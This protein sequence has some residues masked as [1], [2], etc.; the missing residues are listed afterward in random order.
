MRCERGE[1]EMAAARVY[2][3]LTKG[4]LH[5]SIHITAVVPSSA[6]ASLLHPQHRL[7]MSVAWVREP[8]CFREQHSGGSMPR[9]VHFLNV[10]LA[11]LDCKSLSA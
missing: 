4:S 5:W 6:W 1:M 8:A 9:G 10:N 11:A 7:R 3:V 2:V